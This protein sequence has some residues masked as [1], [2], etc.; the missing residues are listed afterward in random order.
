MRLG[1]TGLDL[2]QCADEAAARNLTVAALIALPEQDG[3]VYSDGPSMGKLCATAVRAGRRGR[4]SCGALSRPAP[5]RSL[6]R[7][8]LQRAQGGGHLR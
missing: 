3:W 6:R 5:L 7:L 2:A 1:T 4:D 8:L